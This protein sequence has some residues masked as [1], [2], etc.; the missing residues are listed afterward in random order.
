MHIKTTT[1]LEKVT[2]NC[3][4]SYKCVA[5]NIIFYAVQNSCTG[6]GRTLRPRASALRHTQQWQRPTASSSTIFCATY[7]IFI[8]EYFHLTFRSSMA[9]ESCAGKKLQT[10]CAHP[11]VSVCVRVQQFYDKL[12]NEMG[13]AF[14]N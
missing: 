8:S 4:K 1:L 10:K 13:K 5:A 11:Y 2:K 7:A 14:H 12:Q 9:L 6:N 3:K